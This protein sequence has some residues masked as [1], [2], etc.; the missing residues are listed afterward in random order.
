MHPSLLTFLVPMFLNLVNR[1]GHEIWRDVCHY[2]KLKGKKGGNHYIYLFIAIEDSLKFQ[3]R[4]WFCTY[5]QLKAKVTENNSKGSDQ[6]IATRHPAETETAHAGKLTKQIP[7][8]RNWN[9]IRQ[10]FFNAWP[11]RGF[12]IYLR[13]EKTPILINLAWV[14]YLRNNQKIVTGQFKGMPNQFK[15]WEA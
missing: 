5:P 15:K 6:P 4:S 9:A 14:D 10:Y 12:L 1:S 11:S 3:F 8:I 13:H 7:K 2:N